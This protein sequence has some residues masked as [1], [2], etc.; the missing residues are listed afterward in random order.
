MHPLRVVSRGE[1]GEGEGDCARAGAEGSLTRFEGTVSR[2][3]ASQKEIRASCGG[4]REHQD[5][6]GVE[7]SDCKDVPSQRVERYDRM[8]RR[9]IC[10]HLLGH[11]KRPPPSDPRRSPILPGPS[12]FRE[13]QQGFGPSRRQS[14]TPLGTGF[15]SIRSRQGGTGS[16]RSV[17]AASLSS[18]LAVGWN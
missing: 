16:V 17:Y 1:L 4:G 11:P 5:G 2:Q 8:N 6:L 7:E 13:S 14:L 15:A 18:A 3:F 9:L 12:V 10:Q